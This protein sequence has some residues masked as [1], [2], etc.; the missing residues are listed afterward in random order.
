MFSAVNI[1]LLNYSKDNTFIS[2]EQE[3]FYLFYVNIC[4][5]SV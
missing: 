3:Y 2:I 1:Q 5:L 4:L